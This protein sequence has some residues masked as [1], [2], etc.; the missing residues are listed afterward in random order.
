[1]INM[2]L[3]PTFKD[4]LNVSAHPLRKTGGYRENKIVINPELP[5]VSIITIVRNRKST[6]AKTIKSVLDQT[7]PKIEYIIIDGASTDGTLEIIRQFDRNID[8]WISEPDSGTCDA[9]NKGISAAQGEI[10]SWVASDDWMDSDFIEKAVKG[11][12]DSNADFVF[13][14]L[15][16]YKGNELIVEAKGD[17]D[18]QDRIMKTVPNMLWPSMVIKRESFEKVGLFD[19]RYKIAPDYEWSVRFHLQGG[20]GIYLDNLITNFRIGG[21]SDNA[22]MRNYEVIKIFKQHGFLTFG[23][24][25]LQLYTLIPSQAIYIIKLIFP[26]FIFRELKRFLSTR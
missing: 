5:L 25:A 8:L 23:T 13:G 4:Y 24:M 20:K 7:Y 10:I 17:K 21:V 6:L 2:S 19:L 12:L 1:M 3:V 26:K 22:L 11:L 15:R 16:F 14:N 9:M 18:Y